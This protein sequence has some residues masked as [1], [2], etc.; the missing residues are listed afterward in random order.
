MIKPGI[1]LAIA[2]IEGIAII[3]LAASRH[4]AVYLFVKT[5]PVTGASPLETAIE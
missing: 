3:I 5:T 1:L 2:V 4:H